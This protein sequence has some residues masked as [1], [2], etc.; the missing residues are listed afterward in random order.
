VREPGSAIAT[1]GRLVQS[2]GARLTRIIKTSPVNETIWHIEKEGGIV[3]D[4]TSARVDQIER[5]ECAIELGFKRIA[6]TV[7]GFQSGAITEIREVETDLEA[8][9]LVFSVYAT[10]A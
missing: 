7:A 9:A 2:I 6:V 8:D 4:K 1:D 3:L 5:V 10:L